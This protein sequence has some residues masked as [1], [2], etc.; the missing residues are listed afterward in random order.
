MAHNKPPSVSELYSVGR[1]RPYGQARERVQRQPD[2]ARY[3]QHGEIEKPQM[4]ED[5]HGP[6][7][8]NDCSGWVRGSA[9]GEPTG[10][11]ETGENKPGGFDKGGSWRRPDK[12]NDWHSGHDPATIRKPLPKD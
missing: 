10:Y 1:V 11:H 5:Q 12:G 4:P 6:G 9:R 7:Y 3:H 2:A 8:D